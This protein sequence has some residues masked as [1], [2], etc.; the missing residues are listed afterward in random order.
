LHSSSG[1]E[2]ELVSD[3][4]GAFLMKDDEYFWDM[5]WRAGDYF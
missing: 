3:C 2:G 4:I 5:P 1:F